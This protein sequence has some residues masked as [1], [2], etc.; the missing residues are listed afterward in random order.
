MMKELMFGE[1][2]E[3]KISDVD[4]CLDGNPFNW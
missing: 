3:W 1:D 2:F 4:N